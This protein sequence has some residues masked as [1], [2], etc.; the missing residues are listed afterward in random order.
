MISTQKKGRYEKAV[1]AVKKYIEQRPDDNY[2]PLRLALLYFK[3]GRYEEEVKI[4]E[5]AINSLSF[6]GIGASIIKK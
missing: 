2:A 1:E 6:S 5:K 3:M 4:S